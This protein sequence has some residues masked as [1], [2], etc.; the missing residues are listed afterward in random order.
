MITRKLLSILLGAFILFAVFAIS[1]SEDKTSTGY[2]THPSGW[3]NPASE[4]FHGQAAV[5]SGGESCGGCHALVAPAAIDVPY[6]EAAASGSC[7][8]CHNYFP[9]EWAS[10]IPGH[11]DLI[12]SSNWDLAGC[13]ECHGTDFAGGN[14]GPSCLQCHGTGSIAALTDCNLCHAQ[15][16]VDNAGMPAPYADGAFGAHAAHARY[17]CTECHAAV[18]GLDHINGVPADVTFSQ[19]HI[20]N[21]RD[22]DPVYAPPAVELSGNGGCGSIYCHSGNAM[23]WLGDPVACGSCHSVLPPPPGSF[24]ND[25]TTNCHVCHLH[26]DPNSDYSTPDGI[27]FLPDLEYL[28]VNGVANAIFP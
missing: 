26:V 12:I 23:S 5:P 9:H 7:Y 13:A 11:Q 28:H 17:A 4:E 6:D 10:K 22:F 21:A 16:P 19:A 18:T 1:C 27:H 8:E 15:P 2:E 24:H 14:S 25:N 20:A 3:M